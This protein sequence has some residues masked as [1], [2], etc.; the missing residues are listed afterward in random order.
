MSKEQPKSYK[1]KA[2]CKNCGHSNEL[3]IP[4]GVDAS[5]SD[6]I[7]FSRESKGYEYYNLITKKFQNTAFYPVCS[8]CGSVHL[9]K[10]LHLQNEIQILE[11]QISK[12]W[13]KIGE[14]KSKLNS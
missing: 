8:K 12:I 10:Q 9:Q 1:I 13:D 4:F 6:G 5:E 3:E 7:Y 2:I 11:E 14:I